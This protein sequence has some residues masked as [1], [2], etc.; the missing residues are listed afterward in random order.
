MFHQGFCFHYGSH[1]QVIMK[2]KNFRM[3]EKC[4]QAW[5]EIKQCYVNALILISPHWDLE[6]HVHIDASNLAIKVMMPTLIF[7][8][9]G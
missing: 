9:L 1:Y 4:Q 6:F 2:N 8:G 7:L 5:E 3:D